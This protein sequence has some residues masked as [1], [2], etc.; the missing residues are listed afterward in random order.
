MVEKDRLSAISSQY[1]DGM[2]PT[3]VVRFVLAYPVGPIVG[4]VR[5]GAHMISRPGVLKPS[6]WFA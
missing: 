4:N 6:S 1:L 3:I 2:I 5:R